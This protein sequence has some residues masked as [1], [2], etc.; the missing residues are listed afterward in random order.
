MFLNLAVGNP[1]IL[2]QLG[3]VVLDEAQFIT[4]PNRGISVELLLTL[5]IAARERGVVP[6]LVVLSAVIR[7]H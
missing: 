1:A 2:N 6:Q 7:R 4:D 5:L 3:L